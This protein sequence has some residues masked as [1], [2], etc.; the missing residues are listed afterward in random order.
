MP[1]FSPSGRGHRILVQL[2]HDPSP[3]VP[4]FVEGEA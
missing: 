1:V 3:A 2:A 4:L